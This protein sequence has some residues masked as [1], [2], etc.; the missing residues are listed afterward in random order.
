MLNSGRPGCLV[1]ESRS[2][3]IILAKLRISFLLLLF[4]QILSSR[5]YAQLTDIGIG[6]GGFNYT[7]DLSRTY[8]LKFERPAATVFFRSNISKAVGFR[9]GLTTGWLSGKSKIKGDTALS[10]LSFNLALAEASFMMEYSF[11]DYKS[12]HSRIH[13]SPFLF[14]GGGVFV[15]IGKINTQAKFSRI[16]PIIPL[17]FGIK[18]NINPKFDI[19]L[20]ASTRV[21]FFDYLDSVSGVNKDYR[22][23]NKYNFDVYYFIGVT[24]YYTF[25]IIPCP[26][27]YD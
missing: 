8:D 20:E 24:L 7:G 1:P 19:G 27:D 4:M 13:W 14:I 3:I 2:F 25:Y 23:G 15:P 18:Y 17:G 11:L 9:Y 21:T 26:Y 10:P 5:V 12:K 6:A 16:Q 22:F